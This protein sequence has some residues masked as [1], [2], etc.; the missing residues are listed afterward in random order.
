[1]CGRDFEILDSGE[2]HKHANQ[3][4]RLESDIDRTPREV[5]TARVLSPGLPLV[6]LASYTG[7]VNLWAGYECKR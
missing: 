6:P 7:L 1:M 2:H 4:M 5:N 3:T